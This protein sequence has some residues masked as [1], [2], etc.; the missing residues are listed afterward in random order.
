MIAEERRMTSM[1]E[2]VNAWPGRPEAREQLRAE[3]IEW[4]GTLLRKEREGSLLRRIDAA[5]QRMANGSF[6]D[7]HRCGQEISP[8]R[9][10]AVPVT[11]LC[12]DCQKEEELGLR[13]YAALARRT[14]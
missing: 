12:L 3:L 8:D 5:L 6:G 14:T 4:K 11:T 9:L 10:K 7:C 1:T 13:R 2:A